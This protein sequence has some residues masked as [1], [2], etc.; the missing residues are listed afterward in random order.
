M[1]I[2]FA[3]PTLLLLAIPVGILLWLLYRRSLSD[4]SVRQRQLSLFIRSLLVLL[5]LCSAAGM[6]LLLSSTEPWIV[7]VTDVSPSIGTEGRSAAQEFLRTAELSR[8]R[9]SAT[10]INFASTISPPTLTPPGPADS[11]APANTQTDPAPPET[12][13]EHALDAAVA[14]VP[15]GFVP[16][17]VLLTDGNQTTGDA[18][19]AATRNTAEIWTVPLPAPEAPEVQVSSLKAPHEVREGEPFLIEAEISANHPDEGTVE[20]YRGEFRVATRQITLQPGTNV[21]RF[22]QSV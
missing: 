11:T 8:G 10:W 9:R 20:L 6:T 15:P 1:T 17:I 18:I 19:A 14:T 3:Q 7:F 21:I 16:R 12:D 5:L 4:F 2:E 22:E 13:I